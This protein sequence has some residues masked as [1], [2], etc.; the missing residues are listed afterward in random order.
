[1]PHDLN[2]HRA[3]K[4]Q[5]PMDDELYTVAEAAR[6]LGYSDRRVREFLRNGT[7]QG[8]R[9]TPRGKWLVSA[10]EVRRF[11][12]PPAGTDAPRDDAETGDTRA[13]SSA[14][15]AGFRYMD[16]ESPAITET[17][18]QHLQELLGLV[19]EWKDDLRDLEFE[20]ARA[21]RVLRAHRTFEGN[22]LRASRGKDGSIRTRFQIEDKV[23]FGALREHFTGNEM[24]QEWESL[25]QGID[26]EATPFHKSDDAAPEEFDLVIAISQMVQ[27]LEAARFL[28]VLPGSC[29]ICRDY[30]R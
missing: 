19:A 25:K 4:G 16:G 6:L 3:R 28:S 17:E 12:H 14:S 29:D 15:T 8:H 7:I 2:H 1:M 24:W 10:D 20:V 18:R 27:H 9:P 5:T 11:K 22:C 13:P 26:R 30:R 21:R 23:L